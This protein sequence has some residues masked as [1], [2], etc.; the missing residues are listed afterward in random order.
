VLS[1]WVAPR[2]F[3]PSLQVKDGVQDWLWAPLYRLPRSD[4]AERAPVG[5]FMRQ[6]VL[7]SSIRASEHLAVDP[8][9][10]REA[11]TP[12]SVD[13]TADRT[14][15]PGPLRGKSLTIV[16]VWRNLTL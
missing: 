9:E 13:R 4:G 2:R 3:W 10:L 15:D 6:G 12:G 7:Y 16:E 8:S 11:R 5:A 14:V 1:N